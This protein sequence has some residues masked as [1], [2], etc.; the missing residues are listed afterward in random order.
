M[1]ECSTDCS[2]LVVR[3]RLDSITLEVFS[4]LN[5]TMTLGF[6]SMMSPRH[7]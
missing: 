5:N 6:N 2:G 3:Q 1:T 4:I 7:E